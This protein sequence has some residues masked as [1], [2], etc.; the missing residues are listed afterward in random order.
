[1]KKKL[2]NLVNTK[3]C[4]MN[5]VV[6]TVKK[7]NLPKYIEQGQR[8]KYSS[9]AYSLPVCMYRYIVKL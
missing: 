5:L 3:K 7:F 6:C 8:N 4:T 2:G 9:K 1:M